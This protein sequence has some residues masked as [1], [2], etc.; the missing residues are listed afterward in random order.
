MDVVCQES[1]PSWLDGP[2][3]LFLT[4]CPLASGVQ[5]RFRDSG[6]PQFLVLVPM[7]P[8]ALRLHGFNANVIF[9]FYHS[10]RQKSFFF[11]SRILS[12]AEECYDC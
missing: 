5:V 7:R 2:V 10:R 6:F 9:S 12:F 4:L 3:S 1:S 11:F 8:R